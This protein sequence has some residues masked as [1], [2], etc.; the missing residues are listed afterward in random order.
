MRIFTLTVACLLSALASKAEA[1]ASPLDRAVTALGERFYVSPM[2]SY[3]WADDERNGENGVNWAVSL[4]KQINQNISFEVTYFNTDFSQTATF[5]GEKNRGY[6]VGA[7]LFPFDTAP[8]Y[9]ILAGYAVD[10]GGRSEDSEIAYDAG[11]GAL[12]GP[13][14]LLNYGSL[15]AEVRGRFTNLDQTVDAGGNHLFTDIV[16]NLGVI[17]PLGAAPE[18]PSEPV[19][20]PVAVVEPVQPVDTDGDEVTDDLDQCPDTP[21]GDVVDGLGCS[22]PLS[23]NQ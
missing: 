23:E 13:V 12:F 19:V 2:A 16:A 5:G 18:P 8:I 3:T 21:S 15:R 10:Y 17:F 6:G 4:G 7:L 1:E 14:W 20:E 22:R 11:I 9:G